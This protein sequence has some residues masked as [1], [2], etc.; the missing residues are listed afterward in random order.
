MDIK[1]A[2]D[3]LVNGKMWSGGQNPLLCII[4]YAAGGEKVVRKGATYDKIREVIGNGLYSPGNG[5]G[6]A[7]DRLS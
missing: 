3:I 6:A 7:I 5:T 1:K 4:A 2:S